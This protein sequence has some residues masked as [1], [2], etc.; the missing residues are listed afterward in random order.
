MI[1][2]LDSD[3]RD[4]LREVRDSEFTAKIR[5]GPERE[6][7]IQRLIARAGWS[8]REVVDR[9]LPLTRL[10]QE[11]KVPHRDGRLEPTKALLL[12]RLKNPLERAKLLSSGASTRTIQVS[13]PKRRKMARATSVKKPDPQFETDFRM[14]EREATRQLGY[15]ITI[16]A[17]GIRIDCGLEGLN[18]LLKRLRIE[19]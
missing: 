6:K 12:N 11:L 1:R 3:W 18:E 4:A 15:R 7:Q 17:N 9:K 10:P 16:N 13:I 14:I 2:A 19:L 5:V 8:L